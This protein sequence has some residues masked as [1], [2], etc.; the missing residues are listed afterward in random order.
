MTRISMCDIFY[1]FH[2]AG[3]QQLG[4]GM[5]CPRGLNGSL[6]Q[7][8]L[9]FWGLASASPLWWISTDYAS[10]LC[11]MYIYIYICICVCIYIYI[12]DTYMVHTYMYPC[13]ISNFPVILR[14]I[15]WHNHRV[16]QVFKGYGALTPHWTFPLK[17][18]YS[19]SQP[20]ARV[21][22]IP[23]DPAQIWTWRICATSCYK[24]WATRF[25]SKVQIKIPIG[26]TQE[27]SAILHP[28]MLTTTS[29]AVCPVCGLVHRFADWLLTTLNHL[30]TIWGFWG[31]TLP[32]S[33]KSSAPLFWKP[34]G[35]GQ[36]GDH[37][38]TVI[39]DFPMVNTS[40]WVKTSL[41]PVQL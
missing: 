20:R 33:G 3:C 31:R 21:T 25:L 2:S 18:R 13:V 23:S 37:R 7:D 41:H 27:N 8:E 22:S 9:L 34:T 24:S 5:M 26:R 11:I 17:V 32:L 14:I 39:S 10:I 12:L 35:K 16:I 4:C 36:F 29:H 38:D 28:A 30:G 6:E 15:S 40:C 19:V 1:E